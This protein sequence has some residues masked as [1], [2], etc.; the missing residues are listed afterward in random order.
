M[1]DIACKAKGI[2]IPSPNNGRATGAK[3]TSGSNCPGKALRRKAGWGAKSGNE[4]VTRREVDPGAIV[5]EAVVEIIQDDIIRGRFK[6][7]I[8]DFDGTIS[9]IRAGWQDVMYPYFVD[10]LAETPH[11]EGREALEEVVREF[12]DLLTGKQTI[13]NVYS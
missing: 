11:H 12:V 1:R 9:L 10:V 2:A 3:S 4:V 5:R 8:F 7:A 6:A 13:I